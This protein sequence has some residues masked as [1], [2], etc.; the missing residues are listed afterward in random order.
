MQ[1]NPIH[2]YLESGEYQV[3]LTI[4]NECGSIQTCN[5]IVVTV[6]ASLTYTSMV[7]STSCNEL[8]DGSLIINPDADVSEIT[9]IVTGPDGFVFED[10]YNIS[11]LCAGIYSI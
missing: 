1:E 8:C 9:T 4:T 10:L 6:G 11:G 5:S 2:E 7:N 3:C